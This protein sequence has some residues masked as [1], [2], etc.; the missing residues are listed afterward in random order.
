MLSEKQKRCEQ[1]LAKFSNSVFKLILIYV[2]VLLCTFNK[3]KAQVGVCARHW[4]TSRMLVDSSSYLPWA[5]DR[6]SRCGVLGAGAGE[7]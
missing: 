4:E 5:E 6:W 7:N 1:T 3:E 2:K